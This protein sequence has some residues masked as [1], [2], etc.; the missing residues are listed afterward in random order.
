MS[1]LHE[2]DYNVILDHIGAGVLIF[3]QH[4]KLVFDNLVARRLLGPNLVL[5]RTDGWVPFSM[6]FFD[7]PSGEAPSAN[8]LRAKAQKQAEPVRFSMMI[9]GSVVP[10]WMAVFTNDEKQT[11]TQIVINNPDWSALT[12]LMGTFRAESRTAI[13]DTNGHA[14]F[15]RKLMQHPPSGLSAAQLGERS[16]GMVNLISTK[17]FRLE[18]LID[19][20][21]RLEII[22]TGQLNRL[23]EEQRRKINV[24]DFI[25]DFLEDLGEKPLMDPQEE[26]DGYRKR[27]HLD[28]GENLTVHAPKA[29]FENLLRDTLRNAF[30]YSE[31]NTPVKLQVYSTSQGR[32]V[33][34]D[35]TDQ[36]CG[37]RAKE[38]KRV[39]EPF[40]RA[41]QPQVM[42]EHGYG[43]SLYL[44]KLEVEAMGGLMWFESEEGAGA[45]FH[46]KLPA[47]V[48]PAE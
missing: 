9:G 44:C 20:L 35:I 31:P 24:E 7:D 40:Q 32:L 3:N 14:D 29:L 13:N 1:G 12:E 5:I 18:M 34:F 41:R 11:H 23:I 37:I 47:F 26:S 16:L 43:L 45:V 10:C 2:A 6:L 39:M 28:I 25:E 30:M 42:R 33:Q 19:L 46:F 17:M 4:N 8:D 15:L 48:K 22:R 38:T 27:L 36:G 21:H